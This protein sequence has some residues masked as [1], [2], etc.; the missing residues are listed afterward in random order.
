MDLLALTKCN[1]NIKIRFVHQLLAMH[2]AQREHYWE[3]VERTNS[4]FVV[5]QKSVYAPV[6]K[7]GAILTVCA[8]LK[9]KYVSCLLNEKE[10]A[11]LE[12]IDHSEDLKYTL[13]INLNRVG[14][15]CTLIDFQELSNE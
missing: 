12:G 3:M 5:H 9:G 4:G 8:E 10:V 7:A 6:F 2:I 13:A 14:T 1:S 15:K 11:K